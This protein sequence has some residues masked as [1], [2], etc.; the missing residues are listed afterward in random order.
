MRG[1]LHES[2]TLLA[3]AMGSLVIAEGTDPAV[4]LSATI[5]LD[6]QTIFS[7]DTLRP[8]RRLWS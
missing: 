2:S 1:G 7:G 6:H 3:E 5:A 8:S 4:L